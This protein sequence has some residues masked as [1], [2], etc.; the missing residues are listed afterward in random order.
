MSGVTEAP[1]ALF[2]D[3]DGTLIEWVHY[4]SDPEQVVL[5]ENVAAALRL[6]KERGCRLFLHSNQSGVGRGYFDMAAVE[7][8]NCRM[9]ELMG[10]EADFF[11]GACMATEGPEQGGPGSWRKPSARYELEMMERYGLEAGLCWMV[12]DRESDVETGINAGLRAVGIW[13]TG[14]PEDRRAA[15]ER[16]G[17]M[18]YP[19]VAA[20]VAAAFGR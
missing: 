17:A 5:T 9:L 19:S 15:F 7:A 12:G 14:D 3:R 4:L 2:L 1:Q 6:A 18:V 13:R 10:V 11:D 16:L 8:V 20:F